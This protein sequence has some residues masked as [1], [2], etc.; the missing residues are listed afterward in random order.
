MRLATISWPTM[1]RPT[2]TWT[3]QMRLPPIR[4]RIQESGFLMIY[5]VFPTFV[6]T[7]IAEKPI[8]TSRYG[9]V[10]PASHSGIG[11]VN[12]E[13]LYSTLFHS[14]LFRFK[15]SSHK[16]ITTLLLLTNMCI[17]FFGPWITWLL[18][19]HLNGKSE[20]IQTRTSLWH[21]PVSGC[22]HFLP[23]V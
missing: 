6:E 23:R 10:R 2:W 9:R 3:R 7:N 8:P 15:R 12:I 4:P 5:F 11:Q 18:F 19:R 1:T 16:S 20:W 21:C 13:L 22:C 14:P 17:L